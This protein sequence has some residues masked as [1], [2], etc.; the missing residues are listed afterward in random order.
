MDVTDVSEW[1]V[2]RSEELGRDE[3]KVWLAATPEAPREDWWL[4]K[5]CLTT[6][7]GTARR[8]NHVAEALVSHL[9]REIAVPVADARLA[10]RAG[11]PGAISRNVSP[12]DV[13]MIHGVTALG[14]SRP[15][16]LQ[17]IADVLQGV[18]APSEGTMTSLQVFA[19]FLVLDAWT[20]NTDRHGQNWAILQ[21]RDGSRSL[22]P[23][24]D[25][26]SALGSGLTDANRIHKDVRSFCEKGSTRHFEG[27]GT[28]L[29]LAETAVRLSGAPWWLERVAQVNPL[30]WR[31]TL[32]GVRGLSDAARTF[33]DGILTVNQERVIRLCQ[34]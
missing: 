26:G 28:L 30:S 10:T 12:Q 5:P 23:A 21:H 33:I 22:A 34:R 24:F 6:G 2:I 29:A 3:R 31:E 7:D 19:G 11:S 16:G 27:G 32:V 20:A 4:W 1:N 18:E 17:T 14:R 25:H 9:G 8:L 15:Y 13:Q